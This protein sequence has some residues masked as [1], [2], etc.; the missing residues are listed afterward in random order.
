MECV[1]DDDV[2]KRFERYTIVH[3]NHSDERYYVGTIVGEQVAVRG[4]L[5]AKFLYFHYFMEEEAAGRRCS[6]EESYGF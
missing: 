1:S 2:A 4:L 3:T 5:H 6:F